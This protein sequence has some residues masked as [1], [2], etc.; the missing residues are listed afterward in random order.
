MD[1]KEY[2]Q[3]YSDYVISMRRHFHRHPEPS[4]EE[5][6]TCK[7]IVEELQEMG[8]EP[9]V[10]HT[11]GVTVDIG[12]AARSGKTVMLRADIDALR[13]V[14]ETGEE[15]ASENHGI[16]HA[17]GHDSHAAMLLTA[18]HIL[19]DMEDAGEIN[20]RVRLIFE[21][22]EEIAKGANGMI[23][24]GVM[25]GVDIVYGTHVWSTVD[26][27]IFSVSPGPVMASAD[28]FTITVRGK[29]V[30]GSAPEAGIDPIATAAAIVTELYNVFNR[31]YPSSET[32]V[33]SLCQISGGNTDNAIPEIVTMGGTTRAFNEDIRQSFPGT[34]E[35]VIKGVA[36]AHR[37]EADLDYR[38]GSPVCVNDEGAVKRAEKS[39]A[40]IFGEEAVQGFD[41]VMGGEN[42]G[43]YE[44]LVPGV[45]VFLGVRNEECGAV[46]P[47]HSNRY[48]MDE[49]A[50]IKGAAAAV[51][52][53]VDYLNEEE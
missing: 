50:L 20:G 12:D 24:A 23:A 26:A 42:F 19:K 22:A 3:K 52:F 53:A 16:M 18:A 32:V 4:L 36:A 10:V 35:R 48:R 37:A 46:Y 14:E 27:G 5:F 2:A 17:C 6:E 8:L 41:P 49:S 31:E 40:S 15:F 13:I 1:V 9:R 45:F 39:I 34:I 25:D 30:H 29:A 33:L 21:P 28:F 51:Q 11:T 43:E 44:K 47:Q 38:W 7:R